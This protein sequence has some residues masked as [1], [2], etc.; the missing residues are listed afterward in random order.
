MIA[1]A[2]FIASPLGKI[3]GA[4]VAIGILLGAGKIWL[5]SHDH[6]IKEALVESYEKQAA[7]AAAKEAKRQ[8][9]AAEA[10]AVTLNAEIATAKAAEAKANASLET[11]INAY[12]Q[13]L[14]AAH[15][16]CLADDADVDFI[17]RDDRPKA[18]GL[19]HR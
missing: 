11:R 4:I 17:L 12:E 16:D 14:A 13:Q 19:G 6:A 10:A 5:V 8:Q 15:R 2:E 9:D 7:D 1:L 3:A 18:D